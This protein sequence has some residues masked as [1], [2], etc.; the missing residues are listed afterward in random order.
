MDP[1]LWKP[2]L[3]MG[4]GS[5]ATLAIIYLALQIPNW[6]RETH[7]ETITELR[8]IRRELNRVVTVV[9]IWMV[10][11]GVHLRRNDLEE[12]EESQWTPKH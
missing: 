8:S 3:E 6:H 7:R 9:E 5:A 1:G 12:T 4:L 10:R 2:I 11:Q